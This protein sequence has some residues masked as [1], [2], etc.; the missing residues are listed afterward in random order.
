MCWYCTHMDKERQGHSTALRRAW[1]RCTF[2]ERSPSS[3]S[4][5]SNRG[6]WIT[7]YGHFT[8]ECD[9]KLQPVHYLKEEATEEN[10][11]KS[12]TCSKCNLPNR[13]HGKTSPCNSFLCP[14]WQNYRCCFK[15]LTT[16]TNHTT[17]TTASTKAHASDTEQYQ[18]KHSANSVKGF[19]R[20]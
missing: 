15:C 8:K 19:T 18:D 7:Q 16:K 2:C 6:I 3:C 12:N 17:M 10:L 9:Y 4:R 13:L 14:N 1:K 11:E 5:S 20:T